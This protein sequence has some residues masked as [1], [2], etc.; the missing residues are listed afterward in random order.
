MPVTRF[1]DI[2]SAKADGA[3]LGTAQLPCLL[4]TTSGTTSDPK[5]VVHAQGR[6]VEFAREVA[7]AVGY[8]RPGAC[9]LQA[10]PFCGTYGFIQAMAALMGGA[11]M[12]LMHTFNAQE[13]ASLIRDKGVTLSGMT[14]EMVRAVYAV[15]RET[16]PFPGLRLFVGTRAHE[17]LPLADQRG[18]RLLSGY[19]SSE[20]QA[21]FSRRLDHED[22]GQRAT[23]GGTP[24]SATA[25][26]RA[27]DAGT[28]VILPPGEAGEIEILAPSIMLGYLNDAEATARAFTADGYYRTGDLGFVAT[29]GSWTFLNRIGDSFRLSGF[30]VNPLEIESH[31]RKAPGVDLCYVVG[32]EFGGSTAVVA[33]YT[34]GEA[35]AEDSLR[36][37]CLEGM[38]RYKVPRRFVRVREFPMID[39]MNTRKL[40]R[41][42]LRERALVMLAAEAAPD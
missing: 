18:F 34:S 38:A 41:N 40:D 12:V 20:I 23:G 28:G 42:A 13:A 31:V 37:H 25:K 1:R 16:R 14:D 33:F 4:Y 36:L 22:A 24:V 30:L 26:V 2:E 5:L 11:P 10:V 3:E 9:S 29:D 21:L 15:E 32:V 19:G 39:S 7:A 17:L 35:A 8:D 27:R 6:I